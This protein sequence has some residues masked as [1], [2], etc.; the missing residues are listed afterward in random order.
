MPS[1]SGHTAQV[2]RSEKEVEQI[3]QNA[4][5]LGL[6]GLDSLQRIDD[7][8][9]SIYTH[10]SECRKTTFFTRD[11]TIKQIVIAINNI[12]EKLFPHKNTDE[13][14]SKGKQYQA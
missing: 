12:I 3:G 2:H 8:S 4:P 7:V 6:N 10:P 11:A 5:T 1:A 9:N 13:N 14:F